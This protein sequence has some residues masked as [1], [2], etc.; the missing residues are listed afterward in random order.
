MA[1]H[2]TC[3]AVR[4]LVRSVASG[5]TV[6]ATN[7]ALSTNRIT[8]QRTMPVE[9]AA[10]KMPVKKGPGSYALQQRSTVGNP[11]GTVGKVVVDVRAVCPPRTRPKRRDASPIARAASPLGPLCPT[12]LIDFARW[13][14]PF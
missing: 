11:G 12:M 14:G 9:M 2:L 6:P 7:T 8:Q 3:V 1:P 4:R 13:V 5:F 10:K